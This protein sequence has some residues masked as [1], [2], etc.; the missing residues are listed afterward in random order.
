MSV[1]PLFLFMATPK[2]LAD[3]PGNEMV[4]Y[5]LYKGES[6]TKHNIIFNN[7]NPQWWE[8]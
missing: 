5:P 7:D 3:I 4:S 8:V 2:F 6:T 1:N